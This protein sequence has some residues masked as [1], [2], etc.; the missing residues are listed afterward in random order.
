[1]EGK[2]SFGIFTVVP[3]GAVAGAIVWSSD[4]YA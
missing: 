3:R 4:A 1:M 2:K